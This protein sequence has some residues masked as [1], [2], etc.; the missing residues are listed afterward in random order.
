MIHRLA[1]QVRGNLIA[2][3][4][5]FFAFTGTGLAASHYVI[6]STQ[7]IKPSVLRQLQSQ[8]AALAAA[9]AK[10]GVH[11]VVARAR[12]TGPVN[13]VAEP[14]TVNDPLSG[15]TWTQGAEELDM[16]LG[17]ATVT[18]PAECAGQ[19]DL[20]AEVN[21]Q[22]IDYL[23]LQPSASKEPTTETTFFL[24]NK[25]YGQWLFEPGKAT[26]NNLTLT[27]SGDCREQEGKTAVHVTV[28]SVSFDV[29]GFH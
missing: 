21:G 7:Q 10:K 4:A 23:L 13:S 25:Q 17:Q 12:S 5:L 22:G 11:A 20:V 2:C 24:N 16:L 14:G 6:T 1:G 8:P 19:I 3:L 28:D 15:A 29:L 18:I 27:I 9:V 26:T